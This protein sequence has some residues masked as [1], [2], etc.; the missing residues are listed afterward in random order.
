MKSI[1]LSLALTSF[2]FTGVSF[3]KHHS[4]SDANRDAVT[5]QNSDDSQYNVRYEGHD[6]RLLIGTD[7]LSFVANNPKHSMSWNYNVLKKF[8]V[9]S[10]RS[11]VTMV[12]HGGETHDFRITDG[13]AMSDEVVNNVERRI[14]AA[15]HYEN[16]HS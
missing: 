3:A 12:F 16:R 4:V 7:E 2:L 8:K 13:R 6:G 9:H 11:R 5:A 15:P 14:A 10:D 1:C